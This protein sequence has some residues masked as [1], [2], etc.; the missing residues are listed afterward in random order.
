[1]E[2]SALPTKD[3]KSRARSCGAGRAQVPRQSPG[4]PAGRRSAQAH[5]VAAPSCSRSSS[6]K[7]KK[8]KKRGEVRAGTRV[9]RRSPIPPARASGGSSGRWKGMRPQPS[10]PAAFLSRWIPGSCLGIIYDNSVSP[11]PKS[12]NC[13]VGSVLEKI[14]GFSS[15]SF[16]YYFFF[17]SPPEVS[18]M[19]I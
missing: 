11:Y 3:C 12:P 2:R 10:Q 5:A 16:Y 9:A 13:P 8:K 7:R 4:W 18:G 6:E 15:S 19:C 14:D 1:M 17:L